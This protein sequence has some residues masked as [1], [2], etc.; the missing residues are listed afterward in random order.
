M[1]VGPWLMIVMWDDERARR[2]AVVVVDRYGDSDSDRIDDRWINSSMEGM[3]DLYLSIDGRWMDGGEWPA[4]GR[5]QDVYF[6]PFPS[7]FR[8]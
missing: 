3:L 5:L 6:P 1:I 7:A 2:G 8:Q 4:G